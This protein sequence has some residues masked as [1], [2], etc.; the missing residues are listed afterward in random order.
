MRKAIKIIT[1]TL[2]SCYIDIPAL[3]PGTVGAYALAVVSVGIATALRVALDPYLDGAQFVTFFPAIAITTLISGFGAGFFCAVLSTA[4]A[5]FFVLSPRFS[6]F[7]ESSADLADL[8]LFGPLA[9][10]LVIIIARMRFA[11]EREQ[12]EANKDRLQSALDA[13][14]L[15]SW[16]YD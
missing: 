7:P 5:D 4:S 16:Q 6:F 1:N 12:A 8:L 3:R 10:Y 13:A 11:I 2:H 14:K 9:S 15:G